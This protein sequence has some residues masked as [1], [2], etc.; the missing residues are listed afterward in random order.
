MSSF[1]PVPVSGLVAFPPPP[2]GILLSER[3][4]AP[5]SG[6]C[7]DLGCSLNSFARTLVASAWEAMLHGYEE[8][9]AELLGWEWSDA[10]LL[11]PTAAPGPCAL[12]STRM[13]EIPESRGQDIRQ[14]NTVR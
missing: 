5:K 10:G 13:L 3:K 9:W 6:G 14:G 2:C 8:G 1:K 11:L 7:L 12:I 4:R